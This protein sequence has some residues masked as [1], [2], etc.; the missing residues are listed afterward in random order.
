MT[1]PLSPIEAAGQYKDDILLCAAGKL[2]VQPAELTLIPEKSFLSRETGRYGFLVLHAGGI[3][4]VSLAM[5]AQGKPA[6]AVCA[7]ME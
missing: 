7:P 4:G 2:G 1:S 6:D 5:D 3:C